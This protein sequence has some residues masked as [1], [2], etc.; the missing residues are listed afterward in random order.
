MPSDFSEAEVD[1][2]TLVSDYRIIHAVW[3]VYAVSGVLISDAEHVPTQSRR[4]RRSAMTTVRTVAVF[5][6]LH[7]NSVTVLTFSDEVTS[8]VLSAG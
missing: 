1:V 3:R 4:L 5:L 8:L 2:S 7:A 6:L